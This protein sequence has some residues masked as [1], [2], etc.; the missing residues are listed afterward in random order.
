MWAEQNGHS[1][2]GTRLYDNERFPSSS[3]FDMLVILGGPMGVSDEAKFPWLAQE[4]RWIKEAVRQRKLVLGICLGSQLIAE[5]IGGSVY[6]NDVKEIGWF[7]V[8]LTEEGGHSFFFN[9][10]PEAFVPFHWHGDTFALP[11]GAKRIAASK[12]C[13]NQAF[14]YEG[15]VV[16]LQFH[17]EASETGIAKLVRHC[18]DELEQG[19]Y[20]QRPQEMQGQAERLEASNALLY[21][22]LDAFHAKHRGL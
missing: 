14:E 12:G 1:L 16:G 13:A 18:S 5:A 11:T 22:L 8:R 15:H 19:P 3:A 6:K 7:P 17:L 4:K 10:F 21:K 2:T 9:N 20:I